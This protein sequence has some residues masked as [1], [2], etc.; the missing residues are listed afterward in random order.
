MEDLWRLSTCKIPN[1]KLISENLI[2]ELIP[3]IQR[4][5]SIYIMTS[6]VIKS[7]LHIQAHHLRE[8]IHRGVE[9]KVLGGD[10]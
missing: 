3:G 7:C 2:D 8:D 1:I 9:V 5:S 10:Y 6:F 4:V